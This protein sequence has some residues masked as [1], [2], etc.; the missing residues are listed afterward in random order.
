MK[1]ITDPA[2]IEEFLARSISA[3]YPSVDALREQLLSGKRLTAYMG[4]DPTADYVHLG[5]A[6]NYLLLERLH[7]L[8]HR[9]IVLIG[10]FTAMIGDPTDKG[11]ARVR[12]TREQVLDNLASYKEQIGKI[13]PFDDQENPIELRFNSEWLGKLDFEQLTELASCFTVQQMLERDMFVKRIK[14]RKPLYV[15]EFFYPL[16]Q[17]YD[18]VALGTDIEVGGTDQTFNMLA[19]RILMKR[20]LDREKL[21][22]ATSLIADPETGK[23]LSKSEGTGIGLN[24]PPREMF[25]KAMALPDGLIV[26]LFLDGTRLS[27]EEVRTKSER[28]DAGENPKA[29][30]LELAT[31]LVRMYHGAAEADDARDHWTATF[32]EKERPTDI[33]RFTVASGTTIVD[34]LVKHGIAPSKAQARRLVEDGAITNLD[35]G[36][37]ITD[38]TFVVTKALTVKVGKHRFSKFES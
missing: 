4:I 7:K 1:V 12:L 30:K 5:H 20:Y 22:I 34:A 31:E 14:E 19:G 11:S 26:P 23:K 15:H 33:P 38:P 21:V 28:L 32:S 10:D 3:V 36:E 37:K 25:A 9:I 6:K 17:G 16:M 18:S 13:L 29:L 2:P 24:E 27:L 35:S 8:G